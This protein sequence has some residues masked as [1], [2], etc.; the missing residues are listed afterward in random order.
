MGTLLAGI[1]FGILGGGY[2]MYGRKAQ[3]PVALLAGVLLC[4]FPYFVDG[5]WWTLLVGSLLAA[6][7]FV[8]SW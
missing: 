3:N 6:S 2:F 1:F 5:L 4:L 8:I 7:P